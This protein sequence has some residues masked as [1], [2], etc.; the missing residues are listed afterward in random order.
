MNNKRKDQ[1]GAGAVRVLSRHGARGLT[2]R[3]VDELLG[4]PTGSTS[5]YCRTRAALLQ[6]A[7]DSA[8]EQDRAIFQQFM[9][10]AGGVD[11][12]GLLAHLAS[13]ETRELALARFELFLMAARDG[14]FRAQL[15][16]H[17]ER[18]I[19]LAMESMAQQGREPTKEA[20]TELITTSEGHLFHSIVYG[21]DA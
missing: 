2:H 17:R 7:L 12:D 5:F 9:L 3:A 15:L 10:P 6:L 16:R 8:M 20:A 21:P 19:A 13:P 14:T 18:F 4:L 1:I 11:L